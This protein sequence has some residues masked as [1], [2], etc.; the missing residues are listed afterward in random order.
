MG[1]AI[2]RFLAIA[3]YCIAYI[4]KWSKQTGLTNV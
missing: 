4:T 1:V 2:V 3:K